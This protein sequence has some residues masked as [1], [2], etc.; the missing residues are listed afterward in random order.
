MLKIFVKYSLISLVFLY[1]HTYV[2][3]YV[4]KM[5]TYAALY[6]VKVVVVVVTIDD[7]DDDV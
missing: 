2:S 4:K 6:I 5:C 3:T 1:V 7:D